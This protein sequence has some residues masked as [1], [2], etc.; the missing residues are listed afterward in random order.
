MSDSDPEINLNSSQKL[1]TI[2]DY[3]RELKNWKKVLESYPIP[4]AE[5]TLP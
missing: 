5:S 3:I 1:Q 4:L 2:L